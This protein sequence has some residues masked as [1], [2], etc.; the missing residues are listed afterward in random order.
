MLMVS[1]ML[2]ADYVNRQYIDDNACENSSFSHLHC[3][4]A[5]II[6]NYYLIHTLKKWRISFRSVENMD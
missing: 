3:A 6:I 4:V 5:F 1:V 2:M